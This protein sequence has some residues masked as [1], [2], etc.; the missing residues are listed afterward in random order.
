MTQRRRSRIEAAERSFLRRV[1]GLS[2]SDEVRS[3][4]IRE[5]LGAAVL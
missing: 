1:S 2:L 4:V 3:R 5:G